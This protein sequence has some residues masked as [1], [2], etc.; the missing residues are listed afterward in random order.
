MTPPCTPAPLLPAL[1]PRPLAM[2][3]AW[4]GPRMPTRHPSRRRQAAAVAVQRRQC[5]RQRLHMPPQ[6]RPVGRPRCRRS[7]RRRGRRRRRRGCHAQAAA[8]APL[9]VRVRPL[10]PPC[11]AAAAPAPATAAAAAVTTSACCCRLGPP[12]ATAR[13]PS[14]RQVRSAAPALPCA[15]PPGIVA[16]PALPCA[17]P[18]RNVA[19][20]PFMSSPSC[21]A[22][23]ADRAPAPAQ[24]TGAAEERHGRHAAPQREHLGALCG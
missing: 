5:I 24:P 21:S 17:H 6:R 11:P 15:H 19:N 3:G 23:R 14:A 8:P 1:Q 7:H 20:P 22:R 12:R 16:P 9:R 10:P 4:A 2:R 18:S 13:P